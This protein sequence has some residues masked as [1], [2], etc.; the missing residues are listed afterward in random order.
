VVAP[1]TAPQQPAEQETPPEQS[2][3]APSRNEPEAPMTLPFEEQPSEPEKQTPSDSMLP[4]PLTKPQEPGSQEEPPVMPPRAET[5]ETEDKPPVMP[6]ENPFKDDPPESPQNLKDASPAPPTT[7]RDDPPEPPKSLSEEALEKTERGPR[8]AK[9][10]NSMDAAVSRWRLT[11]HS[12]IDS[13]ANSVVEVPKGDE[14]ILLPALETVPT[15]PSEGTS[16]DEHAVRNPLRA[17]NDRPRESQVT[18]ATHWSAER[19]AEKTAEASRK[20]NPLRDN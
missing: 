1:E 9:R 20:R 13:S 19:T 4:G 6:E 7:S 17:K 12:T 14:P 10:T 5:P 2:L 18:A 3:E 11:A 8:M 15:V 16:V